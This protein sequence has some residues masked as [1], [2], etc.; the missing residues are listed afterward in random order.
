MAYG[1]LAEEADQAGL[2]GQHG[3][4][5]DVVGAAGHGDD[6]GL[7]HVG[8]VGAQGAADLPE[9]VVRAVGD[10]VELDRVAGQRAAGR[11]FGAQHLEPLGAAEFG[12]PDAGAAEAV[13]ELPDGVMVVVGVLA[14][15]QG[16]QVQAEGGDGAADAGQGAVGGERRAWWFRSDR[17][18]RPSSARSSAVA[19]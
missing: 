13:H 8:A 7:D 3:R 17:S 9:D 6:V 5:Q 2:A 11:Q 4:G 12:V 16:G 1:R 10:A 14:D 19:V 15:V 18:S